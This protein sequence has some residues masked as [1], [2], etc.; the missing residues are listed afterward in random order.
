MKHLDKTLS[1]TQTGEHLMKEIRT[2]AR[3]QQDQTQTMKESNEILTKSNN[4][5]ICF[6]QG[7]NIHWQNEFPFHLYR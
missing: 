2:G 3:F 4:E 1:V 7:F 5:E 6:K